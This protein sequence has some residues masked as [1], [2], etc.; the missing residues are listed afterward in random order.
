MLS[1]LGPSRDRQALH[2]H[3]EHLSAQ[4]EDGA[5]RLILGTVRHLPS[6]CQVGQVVANGCRLDARMRRACSA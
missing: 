5:A 4:E 6:D 2:V 3:S 1:T